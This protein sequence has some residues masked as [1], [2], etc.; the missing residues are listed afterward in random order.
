LHSALTEARPRFTIGDDS[1]EHLD[2]STGL[3]LVYSPN[4]VEGI[5]NPILLDVLDQLCKASQFL[6]SLVDPVSEDDFFSF[7]F[8]RVRI[9]EK[10]FRLGMIGGVGEALLPIEQCC[11]VT[12]LLYVQTALT[13]VNCKV[14][15]DLCT[16]IRY[17]IEQIGLES[18]QI[19]HPNLLLWMLLVGG[20]AAPFNND[21]VWLMMA[22]KRS[23]HTSSWEEVE[24]RLERW[25]WRPNY[26]VTWRAAW[27]E[28]IMMEVESQQADEG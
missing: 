21:R 18:L 15:H 2:S 1:E 4:P 12:A 16:A 26:C 19:D 7:G 14:Y 23:L 17:S 6:E 25:P 20:G 22:I 28:A 27:R 24:Q 5:R 3:P 9:E 11:R 13:K 8:K 10:L